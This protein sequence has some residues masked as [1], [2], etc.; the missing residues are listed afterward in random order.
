VLLFVGRLEPQ[1]GI[2]E[3]LDAFEQLRARLPRAM[4][5]LVG[6]GVSSGDVR[7][8]AG[9]WEPGAVRQLGALAPGEVAAWMG[10]CD[11]LTLPSWA[12]GTPNVVLEALASGRPVVATRVGGIPDVVDDGRAGILV[13]ARDASAL[14]AALHD[15]LVRRWDEFAVRASGPGSW[16]ESAERVQAVLES[17]R[18]RA[19]TPG[20]PAPSGAAWGERDL[21]SETGP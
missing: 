8:R 16:A 15:A 5:A 13:P 18:S 17:A 7:A 3:L 19:R 10:A 1:K 20:V 9:Q 2:H 21:P 6:D 12:E 4:L 11:I 14:G